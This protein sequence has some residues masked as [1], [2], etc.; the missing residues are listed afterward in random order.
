MGVSR[1]EA[2]AYSK[3]LLLRAVTS[4]ASYGT[5][6]KSCDSVGC[7]RARGC[8]LSYFSSIKLILPSLKSVC[9]NVQ[10]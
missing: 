4:G 10:Y 6:N 9:V 1:R 7:A 2:V 8:A 3:R 5:K